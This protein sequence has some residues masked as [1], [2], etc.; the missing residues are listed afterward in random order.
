MDL[1]EGHICALEKLQKNS[2]Q[3][4]NV[5]LGTGK[6]V[7]VLELISTFEKVNKCRIPYEY[8]DKRA[9]DVAISIADNKKALKLLNWNPQ[10][11]IEDMC[12]DGWLW[13]QNINRCIKDSIN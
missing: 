2:K 12:I 4:L 3:F 10:R 7:S 6:G 1:A 9:G 11:T 5:N 13:E 8:V